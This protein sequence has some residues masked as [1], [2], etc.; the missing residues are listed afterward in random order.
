MEEEEQA[1]DIKVNVVV[2]NVFW[3]EVNGYYVGDFT[4][5]QVSPPGP[6][7][8]KKNGNVNLKAAHIK[9]PVDITYHL[10]STMVEIDGELVPAGLA[11]PVQDSFWIIDNMGKP[12]AAD[13][14]PSSGEVAVQSGPGQDALVFKDKNVPKKIYTYALALQV[15]I[16]G[17]VQWLVDDPIIVNDGPPRF[18]SWR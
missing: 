10:V 13:K 15:G 18:Y 1:I 17:K 9:Q 8:V 14:A 6:P 2:D 4:Y 16:D 3:D 5:F 12:S 7:I 11:D